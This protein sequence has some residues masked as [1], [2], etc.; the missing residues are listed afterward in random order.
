MYVYGY[1]SVISSDCVVL[2]DEEETSK[3]ADYKSLQWREI[4][5]R[6]AAP[7]VLKE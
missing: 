1:I 2:R 6:Q 4:N 7:S 5:Q 3:T